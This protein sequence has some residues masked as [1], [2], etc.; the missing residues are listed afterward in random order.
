VGGEC[1]DGWRGEL[2]VM[3]FYLLFVFLGLSS[4]LG[5]FMTI[6]LESTLQNTKNSGLEK[7][8]KP[9]TINTRLEPNSSPIP[10]A[11]TIYCTKNVA[12]IL[13]QHPIQP[14]PCINVLIM[15]V[16]IIPP[17]LILT[18][19]MRA[20][21]IQPRSRTT[22]HIT[23]I[24]HE[25]GNTIVSPEQSQQLK[26]T[27]RKPLTMPNRTFQTHRRA[28]LYL[29]RGKSCWQNLLEVR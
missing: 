5:K 20:L 21:C 17:F 25:L 7:H 16:A 29:K 22:P 28:C 2:R 4:D 8:A 1:G 3:V 11:I 19:D 26:A 10:D 13:F 6:I 12:Q 24:L 15:R 27:F 14:Q 18:T 9:Q 23:E